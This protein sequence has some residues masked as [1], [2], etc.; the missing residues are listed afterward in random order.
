MKTEFIWY[1][2]TEKEY[3]FGDKES[4]LNIIRNSTQSHNFVILDKFPNINSSFRSKLISKL[5]F[6]ND[7]SKTGMMEFI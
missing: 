7:V 5:K 1:N 3:Q 2:P 6:L 4:Y